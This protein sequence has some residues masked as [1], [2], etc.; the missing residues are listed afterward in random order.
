MQSLWVVTKIAW[1]EKHETCSL[2]GFEIIFLERLGGSI[3]CPTLD[4]SSDQDPGVMGL[5]PT[6]GS[7]LSGELKILSPSAHLP[8][9]YSKLFLMYKR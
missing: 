5:S 3:E 4:F 9:L 6:L 1:D 2:A 7:V 8:S